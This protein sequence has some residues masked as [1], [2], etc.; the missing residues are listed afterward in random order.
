MYLSTTSRAQLWN[1][2]TGTLKGLAP[3][4][5]Q[6]AGLVQAYDAAFVTTH[7]STKGISFND[8]DNFRTA[9]FTIRNLGS[10]DVT[11]ELGNSPAYSMNSLSVES[12][13]PQAYPNTIIAAA[14]DL[15]F[16]KTSVTV[17]PRGRADITVEPTFAEAA[18]ILTGLLPVYSGYI[19][20]N[21]S[22]GENLAISYLGVRGSMYSAEVMNA[23]ET[24]YDFEKFDRT[25]ASKQ[26][27][28]RG[29][30]TFT[31]P[32]PTLNDTSPMPTFEDLSSYPSAEF[33]LNFGSRVVRADVIPLSSNYT[34]PTTTVL[35]RKIAGSARGYPK[36]YQPRTWFYAWFSGMLDDGYVVPEGEYELS[37]R[38]L[39]LFGDP[40]KPYDYED[41]Y[42]SGFRLFYDR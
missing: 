28:C 27:S 9:T 10:E 12:N 38:A 15:E 21:G 33:V 42:L 6:G 41:L 2:G 24:G 18:A 31:V 36:Q 32:Y 37:V 1:D 17:P 20:I 7:L 4:P 16:S 8:T 3:V 25:S 11:Y 40:E 14:A 30:T 26:S 22:N 29:N 23:E 19:T 39:K 35:G 34:G 13:Y 5:Q